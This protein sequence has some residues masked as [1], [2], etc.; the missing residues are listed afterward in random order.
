LTPAHIAPQVMRPRIL[1]GPPLHACPRTTIAWRSGTTTASPSP[2]L[3]LVRL[4]TLQSVVCAR[5]VG[6]LVHHGRRAPAISG[7][8]KRS[9]PRAVHRRYSQ[10]FHPLVGFA[11]LQ[12][13]PVPSSLL[14]LD[15]STF[16]GVA[17]PLHDV[18][19][20]QPPTGFQPIV[21]R[22]RRFARPR[23]FPCRRPRGFVSPHCRVQGSPYR[24]FP[25]RAAES[26]RRRLLPSRRLPQTR[27][28]QL[29]NGATNP[30]L[31]HKAL[32]RARIRR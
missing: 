12:S 10:R 16:H 15:N 32:L 18:N 29:P 4:A 20:R 5:V 30:R 23:R 3:P 8:G 27:C 17:V 2:W 22:P 7:W 24:G 6:S 25:S 31:A 19:H 21:V 13:P 9:S 11:P 26:P 14:S 1:Q 28:R